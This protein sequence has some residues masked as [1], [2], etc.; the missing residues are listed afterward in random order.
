VSGAIK[1]PADYGQLG[2]LL[3][4]QLLLAVALPFGAILAVRALRL[5]WA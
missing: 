1:I 5:K 4:A 2:E 3:V